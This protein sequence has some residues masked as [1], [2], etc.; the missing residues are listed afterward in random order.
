[1]IL[2]GMGKSK[3]IPIE[4]WGAFKSGHRRGVREYIDDE[5]AFDLLKLAQKGDAK[6]DEALRWLAKYNNETY[7]G[8]LKKGNPEA[9]H[10]TDELYKAA[11]DGHNWRRADVMCIYKS[12]AVPETALVYSDSGA[13]TT[14]SNE[15]AFTDDK[16][17]QLL[18]ENRD[19][20]GHEDTMLDLISPK[21][22][23][24]VRDALTKKPTKKKR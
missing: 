7:R 10:N 4:Y 9:L 2:R 24:K 19:L 13:P 23:L 3:K 20:F 16:L 18:N 22:V 21:A 11:T 6:A 15:G 12:G 17:E 14:E 8:V 1:M 5:Y